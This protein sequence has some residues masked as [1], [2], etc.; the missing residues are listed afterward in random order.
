MRIAIFGAGAVGGYFGGRLAEAGREVVFIARGAHLEALRSHGLRLESIAGDARLGPLTA[1]DDPAELGPVDA[2]LVAVKTWQVGE[3]ARAM[4]PLLGPETFVCPLLNGVEAPDEL[5]A[6]LGRE[7]VLG[8]LCGLIAMLAGP[9][10]VRH[11]GAAP[12]VRFGELDNRRSE[13]VERLLEAFA[14]CVGVNADVPADIHAAM[15]RKFLLIAAMSGVGAVTRA[16][17]DVVRTLTPTRR[18]LEAAMRE[19]LAVARARGVALDEEA[20]ASAL[21]FVDALPEGATASMQRDIIEGR[22]SEL[23]AQNGAVVRLGEAA[24]VDTPVN[25]F[26]YQA[27]LPQEQRARGE[28]RF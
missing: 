28:I 25:R 21:G 12:F 2:V 6:V 23:E 15:W 19:T 4:G 3:A 11:L 9:G 24:G 7:R 8:G 16:P 27:L 1:S 14:G 18:L 17:M 13:R 10:H 20:V 26:L 22:P 5:A